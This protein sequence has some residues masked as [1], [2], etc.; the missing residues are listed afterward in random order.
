MNATQ[1]LMEKAVSKLGT[2]STREIAK[3]VGV[4]HTMVHFWI[5]GRSPITD[6]VTIAQVC[7]AIG[8]KPELWFAELAAEKSA[9]PLLKAWAKHVASL[10]VVLLFGVIAT[11]QAS[12]KSAENT[13]NQGVSEPTLYIM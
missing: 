13:L 2:T 7:L 11:P 1:R 12:A 10:G 4:S 6:P 8:E 5:V 3:V 9:D